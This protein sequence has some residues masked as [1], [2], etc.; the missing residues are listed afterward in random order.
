MNEYVNEKL[1]TN[2]LI[3]I[4]KLSLISAGRGKVSFCQWRNT[5]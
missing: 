5:E 1:A 4:T 3:F 2:E